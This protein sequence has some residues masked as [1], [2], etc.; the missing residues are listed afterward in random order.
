MLFNSL[1]FLAFFPIA[2]GGYFLTPTRFKQLW[3][4]ICSYYFYASWKPEY[5]LLLVVTTLFDFFVAQALNKINQ[6]P[7]RKLALMLSI[8]I[9]LLVLFYFKYLL[10]FAEIS[11]LNT[12]GFSFT[13]AQIILPL[14]ISFYTFQSISYVIDVYRKKLKAETNFVSYALFVSFFPQLVAGPI[15]RASHLISQ[16][17]FSHSFDV[18]RINSGLRRM[19]WGMFKKIVIADRLALLVDPVFNNPQD[20]ST[21]VLCF[22]AITFSFQILA[23]FSGYT[24]I[25]IGA[26]RCFGITLVENFLSPFRA[27][28]FTEFWRRWHTSLNTWFRDYIYHP[29]GG[30]RR[31]RSQTVFFLLLTFFLS[32]L[33]H[34]A[35]F[36]FILFGVTHGLIIVVEY[37]FPSL[38]KPSHNAFRIIFQCRTY[39]TFVFTLILFRSNSMNDALIYVQHLF[40]N[41][42][43]VSVKDLHI[44]TSELL[45]MPFLMIFMELVDSR[46]YSNIGQLFFKYPFVIRYLC[47]LFL[48]FATLFL[49]VYEQ[50]QFIYFQF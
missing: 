10:F 37:L 14:G 27:I 2:L 50:K 15:E 47:F 1:H 12:K 43:S 25:A 31:G 44:P 30:N 24:D 3:L 29:L 20:F 34:G 48:L 17:K 21:G 16:L 26:A 9:N 18:N 19:A 11:G 7:K 22:A 33:W 36:T 28:S 40:S 38:N 4:L 46:N 41:T 45:L 13:A 23:D 6:Q 32:G 8:S 39:L 49:G 5:L 42:G 35:G